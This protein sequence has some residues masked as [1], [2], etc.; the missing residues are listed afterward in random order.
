M[1]RMTDSLLIFTFSPVQSFIAEARRAADLYTGSQVLVELSRAS[2]E[3][4][5]WE[6]IIYPASQDD[7]PN[8]LVA[9]V[10][11]NAEEVAILAR[12][13]LLAKWKEIAES[14]I[15]GKKD[16]KSD[17]ASLVPKDDPVWKAIWERQVAP[18]YLWEVFWSAAE[19]KDGTSGAYRQAYLLAEKLLLAK[20]FNRAFAQVSEPGYP[21]TLSG[22]REALHTAD[23]DG[24]RFWE[25]DRVTKSSL[26][27]VQ[28]R[29]AG[30]ER[31]D[32]F[33]L[34]K[35]F[36]YVTGKKKVEPFKHFPSTSS[37]ASADFLETVKDLP[38]LTDYQEVV[39]SLLSDYKYEVRERS[40]SRWLYDGDLFYPETLTIQRMKN[41]YAIPVSNGDERLA[42]ALRSLSQ[43]YEAASQVRKAQQD[44]LT[45]RARPSPYYAIIMLDGD[46][47]GDHIKACSSEQEHRDLSL[48][49]AAFSREV[50]EIVQKNFGAVVY[51]GGDDVLAMT[52][53]STAIKTA[54]ELALAF[55]KN[56][57]VKLSASAGIAITHHTSPLGSALEAAREAESA[58]KRVAGK[59]A[60]CVHLL[61]RSGEPLEMT[62]KWQDENGLLDVLAEH[63]ASEAISSKLAYDVMRDA[64]A[65]AALEME[66]QTALLKRLLERHS[67][68]KA[69]PSELLKQMKPWLEKIGLAEL[70]KWLALARFVAQGGDE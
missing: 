68:P 7:I 25:S 49:I 10:I 42:K 28:I 58:A 50:R 43:L 13:A 70:G 59:A 48:Q 1:E 24:K 46:G 45:A 65:G 32:A 40:K 11:G 66:P 47:M 23:L 60:V 20:K 4:I 5:G 26:V 31:L 34:V 53:L 16:F 18:E 27:P 14:A 33:G 12:K 64:Y 39:T 9:R 36:S 41:D 63:F 35:R 52:P 15:G 37:I 55:S 29:A 56:A 69:S 17:F 54:R 57:A 44:S 6:R 22:K 38:A 2:A 19:I 67:D 61:K 3:A 62:S 30:K 8:R 51:N 21:D